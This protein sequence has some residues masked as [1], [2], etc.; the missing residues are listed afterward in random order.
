VIGARYAFNVTTPSIRKHV[1]GGIVS[2][3]V[4]VLAGL[5]VLV[6]KRWSSP[7]APPLRVG[8][9]P[10]PEVS[11]DRML[12]GFFSRP[13][14]YVEHTEVSF[15]VEAEAIHHGDQGYSDIRF[16][17]VRPSEWPNIG[18]LLSPERLKA[19]RFSDLLGW[20]TKG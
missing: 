7:P 2:I 4:E 20:Y 16:T 14:Q 11:A 1:N 3:F 5:D 18:S 13:T 12:A 6:T 8:E 19:T 9:I 15:S 17:A 10:S